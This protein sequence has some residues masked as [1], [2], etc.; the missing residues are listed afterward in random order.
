MSRHPQSL[1]TLK[2]IVHSSPFLDPC[3]LGSR[4]A[5]A[6]LPPPHPLPRYPTPS[7][8]RAPLLPPIHVVPAARPLSSSRLPS[9][10]C[11]YRSSVMTAMSPQP[12]PS[13]V[14]TYKRSRKRELKNRALTK[15]WSLRPAQ[16]LGRYAVI[17]GVGIIIQR[18]HVV[19]VRDDPLVPICGSTNPSDLARVALSS[20]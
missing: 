10:P 18:L 2:V 17:I 16:R 15:P 6:P 12:I 13:H 3:V 5:S 19:E 7:L 14:L 20:L 4:T 1:L 8:V 11:S 9:P